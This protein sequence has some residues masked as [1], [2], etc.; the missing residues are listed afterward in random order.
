MHI[1]IWMYIYYIYFIHIYIY[2]IYFMYV[3]IYIYTPLPAS[4]KSNPWIVVRHHGGLQ[5]QTRQGDASGHDL[6]GNSVSRS[7]SKEIQLWCQSLENLYVMPEMVPT[8]SSK[9]EEDVSSMLKRRSITN[10]LVLSM[11]D[12]LSSANPWS[13]ILDGS[14]PKSLG[15]FEI[16]IFE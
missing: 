12:I 5:S 9:F 11:V 13:T 3:Y 6:L 15:W 4:T 1:Y 2:I 8:S 16:H 7:P 14:H 10:G